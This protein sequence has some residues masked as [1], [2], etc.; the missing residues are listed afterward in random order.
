VLGNGKRRIG[1]YIGYEVDFWENAPYGCQQYA[2]RELTLYLCREIRKF[3]PKIVITMPPFEQHTDH[4]MCYAATF[5][6]VLMARC[7]FDSIFGSE[8]LMRIEEPGVK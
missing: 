6:A 4:I 1:E 3:K 2:D 5:K 8:R 7:P